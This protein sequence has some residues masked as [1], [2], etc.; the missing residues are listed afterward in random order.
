MH[1]AFLDEFGH[2]GP[3]KARSDK[4]H[5][6]SPVFGLGGYVLPH[7][8]VRHF[9]TFFL[10]LKS[11]ML[12]Y[13]LKKYG[14]HP[15]TWE[16]KGSDLI[17]TKNITKYR[18]VREGLLRLL[19]ELRKCDGKIIYNGR[20]KYMKPEEANSSG[21]Y[22]T[23][24]AHTIRSIDDFCCQRNSCFLMILDQ[25][26]DRI[27]LLESAT[28]TMFGAQNPARCLLEPPFQVESHLYQTIQAAD[29]IA[30]LIGRLLAFTVEPAQYSDWDWA[31]KYF[32]RAVRNLTSH[33]RVWRPTQAQKQ[34]KFK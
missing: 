3:F 32:G 25:H 20:E 12:A 14:H 11:Q 19:N 18:H 10:Q 23:V 1:I 33:S 9:A 22:T 24:L 4:R 8:Q 30:T 6:Q 15:A 28:K 34:L 27:R 21:L 5:N 7:R 26:S 2:I 29:W 13:E 31:E 16:K 17:T